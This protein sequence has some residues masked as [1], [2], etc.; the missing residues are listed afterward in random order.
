MADLGNT[1]AA[2]S[3]DGVKIEFGTAYWS[4]SS[5]SVNVRGKLLTAR[6]LDPIQP[7]Q[8][9]PVVVALAKDLYGQSTAIVIGGIT[10][11]PRPSTG[12]IETVIPAGVATQIVFTGE[13]GNEY[14]TERF[15]GSYSRGDAVYLQWDA[16][17]P[18]I[19]GAVPTSTI[20][21]DAPPPPPPPRRPP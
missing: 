19:I 2:M 9:G 7:V 6:W 18:T 5:W 15:M 8:G 14:T 12:T 16:A 11:Q 4:G 17:R 10:D 13:D 1:M 20:V 21:P 3:G